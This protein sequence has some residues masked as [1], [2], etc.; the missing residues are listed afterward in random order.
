MAKQA[1]TGM[2]QKSDRKSRG[3]TS[4]SG[5]ALV[6]EMEKGEIGFRA[7]PSRTCPR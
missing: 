7:G 2:N 5:K 1:G 4:I 6:A 3:R